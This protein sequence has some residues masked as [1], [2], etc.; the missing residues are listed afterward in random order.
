MLQEYLPFPL[1][2]YNCKEVKINLPIVEASLFFY[3]YFPQKK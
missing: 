2:K 1:E 3:S